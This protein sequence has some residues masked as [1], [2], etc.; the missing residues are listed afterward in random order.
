MYM[1]LCR[2]QAKRDSPS[3]CDLLKGCVVII[4]D[5]E[6]CR[7]HFDVL[8]VV[9]LC[10]RLGCEEFIAASVSATFVTSKLLSFCFVR[11]EEP[12][13]RD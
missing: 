7:E 2:R 3:D 9:L 10:N 5:E 6:R 4:Y 8:S 1:F 12:A 11:F 13:I